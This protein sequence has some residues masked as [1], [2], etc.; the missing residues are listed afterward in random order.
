MKKYIAILF[1]LF[2]SAGLYAASP[3]LFR[4]ILATSSIKVG[5]SGVANSDAALELNSTT[6]GF[7]PARMTTTQ[8]NAIT[9]IPEG[10]HLYDT[11]K[12]QPAYYNGT[13]WLNI[14]SIT[15]TATLTSKTIDGGSNTL[16]NINAATSF[17]GITP[18]ANGG[19][20]AATFTAHGVLIGEGTSAF[21]AL[22]VGGVG[23]VLIGQTGA[24]PV[25][26]ASPTLSNLTFNGSSSGVITMQPPATIPINYN[27]TLPA[28]PGNAGQ[29][30][31]SGGGG[32]SASNVWNFSPLKN[33]VG[34]YNNMNGD[35]ETQATTH[36]TLG[37]VAV[38]SGL[39][40]S[41]SPTFGTGASGNLSLAIVT[42]SQ[43]AGAASLSYV[44]SAATTVG[45]LVASDAV[46]VDAED[47]SKVLT[48][49]I[50]YTQH[51]GTVGNYS[52]TSSN[53]FGVVIWDVANSIW[54]IPAGVYGM[55][56]GSG[57]GYVT[58]TFQTP[59]NGTSF[60]LVVYNANA[61][62][63]AATLYF[64]D[65][66]LSPQHAPL[67]PA[68]TDWVSYTP[69][70]TW[71]TNATYTGSWRRV[72]DSMQLAAKVALT[73]APTGT[74]TVN[75]P[76]GYTIDAS[77]VLGVTNNGV[78]LGYGTDTAGSVVIHGSA[79]VATTTSINVASLG[80]TGRWS[81]TVP[82]TFG[83]GDYVS[84]FVEV[85]I[86][87]WSSNVQMSSDTDT[88]VV[89]MQ[90]NQASPTATL[91]G[92]LSLLKFTA[93]PTRDTHGA[94]ST[95]TGLYT[96]PVTGDY[97]VTV[98]AQLT[99]SYTVN[100]TAFVG[101]GKNSSTVATFIGVQQAGGTMTNLFPVVTGTI[102]CNVGDTLAPLAS[103]GGSTPTIGATSIANYF[104][105]ERVSGPSTIAA[106]ESINGI[107]TDTSGGSIPTSAATYTYA[108]K[109][110]DSHN[111]YASGTL[112]IPV[113]GE[114]RFTATLFTSG[115]VTMTTTT[116]Y[117]L[118]IYRNGT[119]IG[120]DA[121]F[122]NGA[123]GVGYMGKVNISYPC[124]PGDLITVKSSTNGTATT[125]SA[126]AGLN[127]FTWERTGN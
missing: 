15:G 46:T 61:T 18:V 120:D 93:T 28:A 127:N 84:L 124:L 14:D 74:F 76:T 40:S 52:G 60:R 32:G 8:Q 33:Y 53:S 43:L 42:S 81:A 109:V 55:T 89:A 51:S 49:K 98:G 92:S 78:G 101:I 12:H 63:G 27:F 94:F 41:T 36:W 2:L 91:T 119:L 108:T 117:Q 75:L 85:P 7:L 3:T 45:D 38:T 82:G 77:K 83:N 50:Y 39:P 37:H 29:I 114:Y 13:A 62:S 107:Y 24:N 21:N 100:Q 31:T 17:T 48:F 23:T 71:T 125:A 102:F 80:G 116:N 67:G 103:S 30:F 88:R 9:S 54:I 87:G 126:G 4:D 105:V 19:S 58:G 11:V 56:Q 16:T 72:G 35:F 113:A 1:T 118:G 34:P 65:F 96:C 86:V 112:T 104:Y 59:S 69:T 79:F 66:S 64:D 90:V 115:G 10:L 99:A 47:L 57:I 44:S 26:S 122:G 22:A 106:G 73:G 97:H 111:A 5:G 123:A 20:G 68:M 70:G 95:S 121:I 110:K 25:F 6:K